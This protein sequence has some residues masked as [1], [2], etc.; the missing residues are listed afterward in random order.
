MQTY[1]TL[2]DAQNLRVGFVHANAADPVDLDG[3]AFKVILGAIGLLVV[4]LLV[5]VVY[6]KCKKRHR[7][8]QENHVGN[9]IFEGLRD[10]R[11]MITDGRDFSHYKSIT[12][13]KKDTF[14]STDMRNTAFD[15]IEPPLMGFRQTEGEIC[16]TNRTNKSVQQPISVESSDKL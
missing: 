2:F 6:I 9:S 7:E 8:Y 5:S 11:S 13:E 12:G 14:L 15:N 1:Y 16:N 4:S 10:N 3:D